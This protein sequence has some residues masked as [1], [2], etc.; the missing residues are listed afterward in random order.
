LQRRADYLASGRRY[1]ESKMLLTA[2]RNRL[3]PQVNLSLTAGYSG[4]Q[5][6]RQAG[7]FFGAS[8]AGVPG[9]S[10]T[11]GITYSFPSSNQAARGGVM[12]SEGAAIQAEVQSW[13]V[14]RAINS[15]VVVTLEG[16]RSAILRA[17]KARQSV[18][19]FQ[20]A[21][22]GEREKY[23]GGIGSIVDILSVEDRL[24]AALSDQVQSELAYALALTQ[25]RFATGTL[26]RP[27]QSSQN[28]LAD[29]FLTLPFMC[30]PQDHP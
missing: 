3:L 24:T 4:L 29:T 17:R 20:S 28:I 5:E 16:L 13:Q 6:G 2:S 25:F 9:P 1:A 12:Q 8:Y 22:T 27:S 30:T 10:T 26:V 23:A 11:A 19:S 14:A 15:S 21:L 18:E 7:D